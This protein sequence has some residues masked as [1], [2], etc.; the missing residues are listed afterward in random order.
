LVFALHRAFA[1]GE[2]FKADAGGAGERNQSGRGQFSA[3]AIAIERAEIHLRAARHGTRP[4]R[5]SDSLIQS[6]RRLSIGSSLIFASTFGA[7]RWNW[8]STFFFW[9]H[10]R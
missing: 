8:I 5:L 10:L 7:G 2:P 9:F 4:A 3:R 1:G 6:E